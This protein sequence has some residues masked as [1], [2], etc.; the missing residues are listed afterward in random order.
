MH[1]KFAA[2]FIDSDKNIASVI[3]TVKDIEKLK[4]KEILSDDIISTLVFKEFATKPTF[5][6]VLA[7][8]W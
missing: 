1:I 6:A 5:H 2:H 4:K 3:T 8:G 7:A